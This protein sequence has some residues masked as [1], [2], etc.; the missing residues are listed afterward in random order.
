MCTT[1][2]DEAQ[3]QREKWQQAKKDQRSSKS[4]EI[5]PL[6]KKLKLMKEKERK[7]YNRQKKKDSR[8]RRTAQKIVRDKK[9][10]R[11]RKGRSTEN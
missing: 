2:S 11:K 10:D 9:M 3:K 6:Q 7:E 1:S 8:N 4:E 5:G